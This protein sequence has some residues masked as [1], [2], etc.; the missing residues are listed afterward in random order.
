MVVREVFGWLVVPAHALALMQLNVFIA[1]QEHDSI[2]L[3]MCENAQVATGLVLSADMVLNCIF[4][5]KTHTHTSLVQK[6]FWS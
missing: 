2:V 1:R 4:F 6:K 5:V 3:V